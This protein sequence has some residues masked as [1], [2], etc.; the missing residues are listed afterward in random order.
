MNVVFIFRAKALNFFSI[1]RVFNSIKSSIAAFA[2]IE[3]IYVPKPGFN[4]E[5]IFYLKK[6]SAGHKKA[7]FHVT[8][9]IH[10]TVF[11]LPRKQ[12][13]LTVHDCVFLKKEGGIKKWL[14]KKIYLDWPVRYATMV[15]AIS[16]TRLE[17]IEET[18]CDPS[19]VRVVNNPVSGQIL[20]V[21]KIFNEMRPVMLFIG[22]TPNKNLDR[23]IEAVRGLSCV[24]N[25]IG[26]PGKEQVDKLDE[27]NIQYVRETNLSD[28]EMAKRY[29]NADIILFPSTYEGFKAGR[30]VLT[31]AISPMLELS[32]GAAWT[33][34]PYSYESIRS[35]IEEIIGNKVE[36][37]KKVKM[38]L[39]I[40]EEYAPE[41]VA[42]KYRKIYEELNSKIDPS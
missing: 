26:N 31:S 38:G 13:L 19:K 17:I 29:S 2:Q 40:A 22:T 14:I 41:I 7:I 33:V 36:R 10:Y 23:V 30:P 9:D 11:A 3:S 21:E 25:I 32:R 6:E 16:E 42:G 37:E 27:A 15:T 1:E 34:D 4:A 24:L 39:E 12:C 5:N 28:S 35:G 18:G 8:G 20:F